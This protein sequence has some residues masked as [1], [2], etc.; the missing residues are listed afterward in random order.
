V[1]K[2]D[3]R[4]AA[5]AGAALAVVLIG[6]LLFHSRRESPSIGIKADTTVSPATYAVEKPPPALV[7]KAAAPPIKA[8][9]PLPETVAGK[10]VA[11]PVEPTATPLARLAT[12]L[13]TIQLTTT[14]AGAAFSL[15][16]GVIAN[17]TPPAVEPMR[18]GSTPGA[19]KDLPPGRYTLFFH[20]DGWPDD[21]A[22]ITVSAGEAV[23]VDYT[24]PHGSVHIGSVPDGAEIFFGTHSLGIV[25]LDVDLP[26]GKQKLV[27]RFPNSTERSQSVT[28][29]PQTPATITFELAARTRSKAKA[30]PT[31]SALDKLGQSLKHVFGGK[32]PTPAPRK[33]H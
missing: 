24:F 2:V 19:M 5:A 31:P 25:P 14:P 23:P 33:K 30:T 9:S 12:K 7:A 17:K 22:E 1:A 18:T 20:T 4:I 21:R 27:A 13:A 29:A 8:Q 3:R 6:M 11:A 15:Y 26:L 28:I 10:A 16:P 32:S